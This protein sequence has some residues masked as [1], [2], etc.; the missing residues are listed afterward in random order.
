MGGGR[1]EDWRRSGRRDERA[2]GAIVEGRRRLLRAHGGLDDTG[3]VTAA[4][5]SAAVSCQKFCWRLRAHETHL[6][7]SFHRFDRM[8]GGVFRRDCRAQ[9]LCRGAAAKL[10]RLLYS[11]LLRLLPLHPPPPPFLL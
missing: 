11:P 3:N 5:S 9:H 6:H 7:G 10:V 8:G 1:E 2:E 4:G